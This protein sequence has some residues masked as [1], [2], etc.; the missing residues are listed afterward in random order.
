MNYH[1]GRYLINFVTFHLNVND[2]ILIGVEGKVG[3][4]CYKFALHFWANY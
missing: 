4:Q 2:V 3:H 1:D